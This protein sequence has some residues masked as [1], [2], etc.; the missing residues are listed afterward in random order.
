MERAGFWVRLGATLLDFVLMSLVWSFIGRYF[1]LA[2]VF[3]HIGMW[4]W[5]GTTIGGIVMGLKI[6]RVDGTP[7][8]F[9]IALV[10]SLS[11]FFSAFALFIGF[12]W[13]GW[14]EE[15]QAWHDKIAG[16]YIVKVPKGVSLI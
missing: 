3:Y 4:T 6:V 16:T 14:D 11:S 1:L 15:K 5:K 12:F 7:I 8:N 9:S 13:A 2:W 10:R